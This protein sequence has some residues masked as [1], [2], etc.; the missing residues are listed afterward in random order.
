MS[1]LRLGGATRLLLRAQRRQG[2]DVAGPR[3][4]RQ[5]V[6]A[7]KHPPDAREL[8]RHLAARGGAAEAAPVDLAPALI[9]AQ[10]QVAALTARA[11]RRDS[12]VGSSRKATEESWPALQY[13]HHCTSC[14]IG[15]SS[16]CEHHH[17]IA[18]IAQNAHIR[19]AFYRNQGTSRGQLWTRASHGKGPR[20]ALADAGWGES[21]Y[22]W[23][24]RWAAH[25]LTP[26]QRQA[27][28]S[29]AKGWRDS[30]PFIR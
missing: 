19:H 1:Q 13:M 4:L 6:Q 2:V 5:E 21:R 8:Q 14:R 10:E 24:L 26:R 7:Q 29:Q 23:R 11:T 9:V 27:V 16:S 17:S 25:L 22:A 30:R 12:K 20:D 3:A 15:N 18:A 28:P